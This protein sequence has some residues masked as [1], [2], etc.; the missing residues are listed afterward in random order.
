[1][2]TNVWVWVGLVVVV[3]VGLFAW[4][5]YTGKQAQLALQAQNGTASTTATPVSN[6]IPATPA[7][8]EQ[9]KSGTIVSVLGSILGGSKFAALLS[10]TG[11]ASQLSG[12]GPYTLFVP[13]NDTFS[14]VPTNLSSADKKRLAQYHV[15]SGKNIDVN[16]QQ[17]G[18]IQALSKDMLN[19]SVRQGDKSARVNSSV[20]LEKY[21]TSNGTIYL[22]DQVLL[23]PLLPR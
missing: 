21:T 17:S 18:T 1:M 15:V 9:G 14:R 4:M 5:M 13:I 20:A 11:V 12:K 7:V 8:K 2:K 6:T 16:I 3:A 10:S 19:F 22:I 23:P